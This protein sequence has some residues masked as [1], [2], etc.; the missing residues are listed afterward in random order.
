MPCWFSSRMVRKISFVIN[1]G[2]PSEGSSR[3]TSAVNQI[4]DR[5]YAKEHLSG[6]ATILYR[7]S[8]ISGRSR[9]T[10]ILLLVESNI[11]SIQSI[12]FNHVCTSKKFF[13]ASCHDDSHL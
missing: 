11:L 13:G 2:S 12:Q 10:P 7:T 4:V 8:K 5:F 6:V 9:P 3:M 1:G